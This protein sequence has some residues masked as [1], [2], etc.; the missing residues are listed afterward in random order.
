MIAIIIGDLVAGTMSGNVEGPVIPGHLTSLPL[1][2]L[3]FRDGEVIDAGTISTFYVDATGMKHVVE[4][5]E[6]QQVDCAFDDVLIKDGGLWRVINTGDQLAQAKAS[7]VAR[8]TAA[9]AAAIVG[10]Y[11]S[12]S[13]GG[14][15]RYPSAITDQINMMG[16]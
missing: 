9:C 3:R 1:S 10:G 8:L 4:G 7:A 2:Q 14:V 13:L 6:T 5:D 15:Q 12:V 16:R 11:S